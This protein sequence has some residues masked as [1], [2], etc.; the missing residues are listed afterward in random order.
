MAAAASAT[1]LALRLPC[2]HSELIR[3][4]VRETVALFSFVACDFLGIVVGS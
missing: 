4:K 1:S 3:G 2:D